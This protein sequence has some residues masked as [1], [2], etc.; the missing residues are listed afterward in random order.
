MR[1]ANETP[2]PAPRQGQAAESVLRLDDVSV[3][4]EGDRLALDGISLALRA[5]EILGVVGE[6]GAGKSL[7]A[8]AILGLLPKG[9]RLLKG[10]ITY[11]GKS[12]SGMSRSEMRQLRGGDIAIIG[13]NA[14]SLLDPVV[15]VGKQIARVARAHGRMSRP[16]ARAAAIA[17]LQDVGITNA[18]ERAAAYPHELS[19]G[20]A[21]RVVI[22]MALVANPKVLLADDATLGLDATVQAQVLDNLVRRC[23]ERGMAAILITHDL[24]I[25]RHYCDRV[26]VMRGGKLI[27]TGSVEAFL[28]RPAMDYSRELVAAARARPAMRSPE[29]NDRQRNLL[30]VRD[31]TMHFATSGNAGPIRAVDGVSFSIARGETLAL[32][33]ESGSGKTTTGQCI[34]RLLNSTNGRIFFDGTD[35]SDMSERQFRPLRRRIQMVFQ[36]PYVALNPRWRVADLLSEPFR[37]L[38]PMTRGERARRVAQLLEAVHIDPAFAGRYPHELTAGE[39]KRVGV[40]RALATTPDFVVFDEPTTALDIRVRAQIIDLIRD[41]QTRMSLSALFITHDLNSVRS[42]AHKVAVMHLGKIVEYGETE[43]IFET[44]SEAYT[45]KLLTAELSTDQKAAG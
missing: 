20:M 23:R 36:E 11:G 10:D 6:T 44:P 16:E 14:K 31:L 34:L 43:R 25:V 21:Q 2:A 12:V 18:E 29:R 32:V 35:V 5:N 40:A 30:D 4:F 39:Q 1:D 38:D 33:G 7:L 13:T 27:E 15:P 9:G 8:Q 24:G 19:G 28:E 17:L 26:A 42:L 45:K 3:G 22:A 37:L 41:L